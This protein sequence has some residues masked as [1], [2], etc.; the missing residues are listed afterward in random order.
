M[1]D[2]H[3]H[4]LWNVD[5]GPKT[6][7]DTMRLFEQAVK[8]GIKEIIATPHCYHPLYHANYNAVKNQIHLLQS[9][10]TKKSIPLTLFTGHEVRLSEKIIPL[11]KTNQI[12]TLACSNYM[13]LELPSYTVPAYTISII[14]SLLSEGITPIIAHPERNKAIVERPVYL[15]R[16]ICEGA[17][18]QITAGSLAGYFGRTIQKRSLELVRANL[19]HTYG[20]DVHNQSSRPFFFDAGLCYLEKKKELDSIDILL[21]NN[22]RII[23]NQPFIIQEPCKIEVRKWW[24]IFKH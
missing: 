22:A 18:A 17:K 24:M 3:S 4:I 1:V 11:Y 21:E 23:E 14:R 12:H 2:M 8:E 7:A 6:M 10:L 9:E 16:L 20:S 19:V 13:L 5:D 15:E